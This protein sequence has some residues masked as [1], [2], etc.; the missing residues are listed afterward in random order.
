L[1]RDFPEI[2][3]SIDG[4]IG[5]WPASRRTLPL[6]LLSAPS[7]RELLEPQN[8]GSVTVGSNFDTGRPRNQSARKAVEPGS[9]NP[10][11]NVGHPHS[12]AA[13]ARGGDVS[14]AA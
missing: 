13:V 10:Q 12:L 2:Q 14:Q 6:Q 8:F 4:I 7:E 3:V 11:Q 1:A 9:H 5:P